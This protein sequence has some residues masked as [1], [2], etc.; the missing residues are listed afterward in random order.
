VHKVDEDRPYNELR[1]TG[2]FSLAEM[3]AWVVY[4]LPE[5]PTRAPDEAEVGSLIRMRVVK[6]ILADACGSSASALC[7]VVL[8]RFTSPY[9]HRMSRIS[10]VDSILLVF[11]V[12]V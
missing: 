4:C 11:E 10:R 1:I 8:R 7:H 12:P 5:I 3:H 9:H 2:G 6:S